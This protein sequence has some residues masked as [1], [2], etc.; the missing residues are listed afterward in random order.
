[1][2]PHHLLSGTEQDLETSG[3]FYTFW[4]PLETSALKGSLGFHPGPHFCQEGP[5]LRENLGLAHSPCWSGWVHS[6]L[7]GLSQIFLLLS[8]EAQAESESGQGAGAKERKE[9]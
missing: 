1:M 2:C 9:P 4:L 3:R 5:G 8:S 7:P 6:A